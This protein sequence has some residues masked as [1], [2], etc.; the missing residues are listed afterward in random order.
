MPSKRYGSSLYPPKPNVL[1]VYTGSEY[2]FIST[3]TKCLVI[4]A[5]APM[6]TMGSVPDGLCG[7]RANYLLSVLKTADVGTLSPSTTAKGHQHSKLLRLTAD[8]FSVC[9]SQSS[10]PIYENLISIYVSNIISAHMLICSL[11]CIHSQ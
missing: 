7:V 2:L 5:G 9:P 8:L 10:S 3:Q 6:S 11:I 4:S 1:S